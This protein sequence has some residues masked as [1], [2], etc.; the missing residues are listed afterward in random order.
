MNGRKSPNVLLICVDQWRGDCLSSQGHP[1]VK[2]PYL[3]LLARDGVNFDAAYSATPTCVPARVALMTGQSQERHGRVG[4]QDLVPFQEAHPVP[5]LAG[6]FR[7]AGYQTQ[8][9][10]KMH[11]YPERARLGFDDIRLHDGFL[12]AARRR[13]ERDLASIDDYLPWLRKQP[14]MTATE[15]YTDNGL[16]CN[17]YTARPW[18][19]PESTHPSNWVV[20]E[21]IDWL[22]RRDTTA[23]FFLYLSFHRPH[24]PFD[25]P[26]WA[27]EQYLDAPVADLPMG[28]WL[29]DYAEFRADGDADAVVGAADPESH[30]RAVAGY[31]GHMS[32]IDGQIERFLAALENFQLREETIVVFT[33]DHGDMMGDHGM[34]RKG[35]PYQGSAR[36]PLIISVPGATTGLRRHVADVVELRDLMPTLLDAAGIP[37]PDSVDGKSLLPIVLDPVAGPVREYLHGEHVLLGQSLQWLT[38]GRR[39]FVWLSGSGR[40]QFFDLEQDPQELS[41]LAADPDRAEEVGQWRDRL[42]EALEGREEEFVADGGLLAGRLVHPTAARIR[43]L[44]R[45]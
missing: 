32:H 31:Y 2:T 40:E 34:Y 3:D 5:T 20:T 37:V 25:P 18:D 1:V 44:A 35:Q 22:H 28:D 16:N 10:G 33:S 39:K 27:F 21:A 11:V 17:S 15:D 13:A 24:P 9:V 4:Y 12:H 42:I 14:G 8:C 30:R 36:I 43:G 26:Q 29:D 41:N 45:S 23:P 6:S 38:D 7:D 19:K